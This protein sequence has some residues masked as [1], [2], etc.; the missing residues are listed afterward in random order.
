LNITKNQ[1]V[2][3]TLAEVYQ[4][5]LP[6]TCQVGR[7]LVRH[8]EGQGVIKQVGDVERDVANRTICLAARNVS[9]R[10]PHCHVRVSREGKCWQCNHT[11]NHLFAP[12][13]CE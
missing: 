8:V 4:A 11:K 1:P 6:A 3:S 12:R 9:V 7:Q 2:S 5:C 10:K 13:S